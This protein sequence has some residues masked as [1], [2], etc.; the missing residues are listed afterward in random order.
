MTARE[1]A[2]AEP[3]PLMKEKGP[4]IVKALRGWANWSRDTAHLR[5]DVNDMLYV[6]MHQLLNLSESLGMMAA[7]LEGQI[8]AIE[9]SP[10]AAERTA[11]ADVAQAIWEN[12]DF[13][14]GLEMIRHGIKQEQFSAY[15]TILQ[16]IKSVIDAQERAGE[17]KNETGAQGT[18]QGTPEPPA[19]APSSLK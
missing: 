5:G 2:K 15:T 7:F 10:P 1:S 8:R 6:D 12:D 9:A 11:S 13:Q 14:D 16:A 18:V 3:T 19:S 17:P 4:E